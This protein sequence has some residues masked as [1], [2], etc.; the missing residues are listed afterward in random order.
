MPYYFIVLFLAFSFMRC[1]H[2]II[3]CHLFAI[4]ADYAAIID[5]YFIDIIDDAFIIIFSYAIISFSL[6]PYW[7]YYIF[8]ID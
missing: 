6:M 8:S 2:Y 7:H 3:S 4:I 1:C 5:Y